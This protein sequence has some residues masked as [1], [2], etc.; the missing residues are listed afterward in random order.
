MQTPS[1]RVRSRRFMCSEKCSWT[2]GC[3]WAKKF[4]KLKPDQTVELMYHWSQLHSVEETAHETGI[5]ADTV[6]D[7]YHVCRETTTEFLH[8]VTRNEKIGGQGRIVCIDET[9][10][11]KKKRNRGGFQG[12]NTLAHETIIMAGVELDGP[13]AGRKLTGRAFMVVVREKSAET[14]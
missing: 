8:K 10:I 14:F 6:G 12:R 3:P 1:G 13:W 7:F 9:H 11:T 5:H 2:D 4:N